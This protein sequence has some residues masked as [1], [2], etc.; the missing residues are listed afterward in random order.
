M[1]IMCVVDTTIS[2]NSTLEAFDF[3]LS[4]DRRYEKGW[5]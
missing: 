1:M 3:L 2:I 5:F 4:N